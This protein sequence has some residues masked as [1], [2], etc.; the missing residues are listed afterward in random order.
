MDVSG[1]FVFDFMLSWNSKDLIHPVCTMSILRCI[2]LDLPCEI[3]VLTIYIMLMQDDYELRKKFY[4]TCS[5]IVCM[6][7]KHNSS[8]I[9]N[10]LSP[11]S[12]Y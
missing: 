10:I 3:S 9:E 1:S 11:S 4:Y 7:L 6:N 8:D 12:R 5:N 2:F